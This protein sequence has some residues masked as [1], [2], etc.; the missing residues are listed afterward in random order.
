MVANVENHLVGAVE[1]G[2]VETFV[3][4]R[5]A[6]KAGCAQ[7]LQL[8]GVG[9]DIVDQYAEVMDAA[10]IKSQSLVPA[11]MQDRQIQRAIGQEHAVRY[12]FAL[13]F[14]SMDL[15]EVECLFIK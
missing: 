10:E 1:L 9:I 3:L 5:P 4:F 13:W 8:I 15:D 11:E 14:G 6:R 2:L 7:L 12:A